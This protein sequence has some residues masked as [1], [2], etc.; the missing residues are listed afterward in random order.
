MGRLEI[1]VRHGHSNGPAQWAAVVALI[2]LA[3]FA[4]AGHHQIAA[5]LHE[6][7]AAVEIAA[8]SAAGLGVLA[9]ILVIARARRANRRRARYAD[10][11]AAAAAHYHALYH[12]GTRPALGQVRPDMSGYLPGDVVRDDR[13]P[14]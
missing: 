2:V 6:V 13:Y 11:R 3:L 10:R 1:Q 7:L 9:L 14:Y 12:D 8:Y 4:A 5:M